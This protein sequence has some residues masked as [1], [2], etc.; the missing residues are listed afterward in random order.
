MKR[1]KVK[2]CKNEEELNKFLRTLPI[3]ESEDKK[4]SSSLYRITYLPA[5]D[6]KGTNDNVEIGTNVISIVEYWVSE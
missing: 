3:F 4:L 6:G 5:P 1:L 2:F